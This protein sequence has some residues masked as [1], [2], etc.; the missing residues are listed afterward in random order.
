VA[1]EVGSLEDI[2]RAY[3]NLSNV[4]GDVGGRLEEGVELSRQG[5]DRMRQLGLELAL[6]GNVFRGDL[7]WGLWLLGRWQQA[8]ELTADALARELPL[9]FALHM[10]LLQGRLHLAQGRFDLAQVQGEIADRMVQQMTDIVH[11]ALVQEYLAELG[12]WGG[13]HDAAR[14]AVARGL[15]YLAG[16]DETTCM[17]WLCSIGLRAEADAAERIFGQRAVRELPAIRTVAEALVTQVRRVVAERGLGGLEPQASAHAAGCEAEFSRLER[18]SDPQ[19]W[20]GVVAAWDSLSRPYE[21][22]YARWRY[23]EALLTAK[24]SRVA[25]DVL[26]GAYQAA[27]ELGARPLCHEI[28]RLARRAR[29]DLR[30]AT[31][32]AKTVSTAQGFTPREQEVLQHL[33]EGRTN[34]QIARALFISEKTASV[35][36]SNIMRKLG[37]D[38]RT[39][40]AAIA[41]RLRLVSEPS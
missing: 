27:I 18:K 8:A 10:Q 16:S 20:A 24:A 7:A 2:C 4:V 22:A 36:V 25:A 11:H 13:D 37:A 12:I 6:P 19:L 26:R 14:S 32:K 38:N 31:P 3:T 30:P 28:E 29:I 39:E 1:E 41:H 35:H 40:A 17:T 9:R 15:G 5:L 34:R 23:A 33:M 21:A